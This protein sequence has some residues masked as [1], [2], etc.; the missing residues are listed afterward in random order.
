MLL[1]C[2]SMLSYDSHQALLVKDILNTLLEYLYKS[3]DASQWESMAVYLVLIVGLTK[4]IS[5]I[6]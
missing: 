6:S 4:I 3:F 5:P 2:F 1:A